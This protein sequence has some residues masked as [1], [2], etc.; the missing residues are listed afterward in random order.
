MKHILPFIIVSIMLVACQA[1]QQVE[2]KNEYIESKLNFNNQ[3]D[4][5]SF[6]PLMEGSWVKSDYLEILEKTK[7][8]LAAWH[9]VG[10]VTSFY[11]NF[12]KLK[13]DSLK[14]GVNYGNH[15][16]DELYLYFREISAKNTFAAKVEGYEKY[17]FIDRFYEFQLESPYIFL[18]KYDKKHNLLETTK[19]TRVS[20]EKVNHVTE[21]LSFALNSNIIAGKYWYNNQEIFFD[22]N[23]KTNFLG[24]SKYNIWEDFNGPDNLETDGLTLSGNQKFSTLFLKIEKDSLLFFETIEQKDEFDQTFIAGK[25][26]LK[27]TL[28][29]QE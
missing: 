26:E 10:D 15:E 27:Y 1:K 13:G 7:S 23:G 22:N 9:H 20:T 5:Q 17:N 16:G 4:I 14:F 19:Y 29:K 25:G 24:F 28:L 8:S 12:D 2:T 6:R 3:I 21:G 18:R 11:F